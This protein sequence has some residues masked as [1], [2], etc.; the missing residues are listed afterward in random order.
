[1][2]SVPI[3]L[4]VR[5]FN[6][7]KWVKQDALVLDK[8]EW[9]RIK[10]HM[11]FLYKDTEYA[12]EQHMM[13][14]KIKEKSQL[15][16]KDWD[17][18]LQNL[19]ERRIAANK[20]RLAAIEKRRN[21]VQKAFRKEQAA[22]K[23]KYLEDCQKALYYNKDNVKMLN[24]SLRFSEILR[25]R[26]EQIKFDKKLKELE[27]QKEKEYA[28]KCRQDAEEYIKE[29]RLRKKKQLEKM[30]KHREDL[31]AQIREK[32][33]NKL[34][35]ANETEK[36]R[37][38]LKNTKR[39]LELAEEC[40]AKEIA[41]KKHVYMQ[42]IRDFF[43]QERE[44]KEER[45]H[46]EE[47]ENK[48][49]EIYGKAR[50]RI[51]KM[52][53]EKEKQL[54][55][56]ALEKR[57]KIRDHLVQTFLKKEADEDIL[58]QRAIAEKQA[59]AE[60]ERQKK[61]RYQQQL[62]EERIQ[63]YR[64]FLIKEEQIKKE[65]EEIRKWEMMQRFKENEANKEFYRQKQEKKSKDIEEIRKYYGQQI[66]EREEVIRQEREEDE[67]ALKQTLKLYDADDQGLLDYA[68]EIIEESKKRGRYLR[69]ILQAEMMY[70]NC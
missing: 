66:K 35:E 27:E 13:R 3:E 54:L 52:R 69:P 19:R 26:Q 45:Q 23:K 34:E 42:Q 25:T 50:R 17:N 15:I 47:I 53:K 67:K 64:D 68:K 58:L 33:K 70:R 49:I 59:I 63:A 32:E 60:E 40:E 7:G 65:K 57:G 61:L 9:N 55:N 1:M 24:Q 20:A 2:N 37:E 51:E 12:E 10:G 39:E 29:K 18:T 8:S 14:E 4:P 6:T 31:Q 36:E 16:I 5:E 44:I 41:A 43:D 62:K 11:Q 22:E 30:Q 28:E 21:D 48:L 38:D 46:K 56:E